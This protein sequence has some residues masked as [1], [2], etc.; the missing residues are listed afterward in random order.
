MSDS[1]P[2][3]RLAQ[4]RASGH[5]AGVKGLQ[6]AEESAVAIPTQHRSRAMMN[7]H[8]EPPWQTRTHG[9]VV[10]GLGQNRFHLSARDDTLQRTESLARRPRRQCARLLAKVD[11]RS[12][13]IR[14]ECWQTYSDRRLFVWQAY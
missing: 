2:L 8:H 12:L 13:L 4:G 5:G 10:A 14:F 6:P 11:H 7:L 3:A 9:A 1:Q